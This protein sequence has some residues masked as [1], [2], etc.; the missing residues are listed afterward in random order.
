[1]P[2]A[3]VTAR[4]LAVILWRGDVRGA[5]FPSFWKRVVA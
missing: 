1:V 4:D 5:A 3:E 2:L